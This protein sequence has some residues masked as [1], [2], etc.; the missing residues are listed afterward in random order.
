MSNLI[1]CFCQKDA[2][3]HGNNPFPL[4]DE[5]VCC[6]TCNITLVVAAR[7]TSST[8][9]TVEPELSHVDTLSCECRAC[10][11]NAYVH[12]DTC[13]CE[14]CEEDSIDTTFAKKNVIVNKEE[15]KVWIHKDG[16]LVEVIE[17]DGKYTEVNGED[18]WISRDGEW[19][20]VDSVDEQEDVS[21]VY[22][23]R[24]LEEA[25][26]T[27]SNSYKCMICKDG[28]DPF[29]HRKCQG[30][31][32]YDC[33]ICKDYYSDHRACEGMTREEMAYEDFCDEYRR[34][35]GGKY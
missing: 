2:G 34:T 30:I 14:M 17:Q 5:G 1:C 29:D 21:Q 6:D 11:M 15:G 28:I 8:A 23:Q 9:R 24:A 18:T 26:R 19:V 10:M 33:D 25:M 22:H 31:I 32:P 35:C 4:C 3:P 7:L 20:N 27:Q 12:I 16:Q 13:K